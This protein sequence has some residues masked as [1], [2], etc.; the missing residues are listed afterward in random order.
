MV[1]GALLDI[2]TR[3]PPAKIC[4]SPMFVFPAP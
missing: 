2:R 3:D 4:Q 1:G